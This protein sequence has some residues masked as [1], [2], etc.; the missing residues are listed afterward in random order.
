[1][2]H[3]LLAIC[4]EE[5]SFETRLCKGEQKLKRRWLLDYDLSVHGITYHAET[6]NIFSVVHALAS[7]KVADMLSGVLS[8]T[9]EG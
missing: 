5:G 6:R 8:F 2:V 7:K 1:M 3:L 9:R 4:M